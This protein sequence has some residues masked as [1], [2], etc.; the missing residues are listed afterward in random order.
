MATVL[1][2][3]PYAAISVNAF[4]DVQKLSEVTGVNKNLLQ[5]FAVILTALSSFC[6]IDVQ[7]TQAQPAVP[8][9]SRKKKAQRGHY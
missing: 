6:P 7:K 9:E 4:K 3:M 1:S 5:R 2:Y 8:A